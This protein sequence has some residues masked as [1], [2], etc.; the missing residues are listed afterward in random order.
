MYMN[1][2]KMAVVSGT[3]TTENND[4]V[5]FSRIDYKVTQI[6]LLLFCWCHRE[7]A[8]I[9]FLKMAISRS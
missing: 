9:L 1:K 8:E 2:I 5:S 7:R 3:N 4:R 6:L